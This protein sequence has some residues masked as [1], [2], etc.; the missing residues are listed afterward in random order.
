MIDP[1][2]RRST[3][4]AHRREPR[5]C[6][7]DVNMPMVIAALVLALFSCN[8]AQSMQQPIDVSITTDGGFTGRGL[9]TVAIKDTRV[10]TDRCDGELTKPEQTRIARL[11]RD[12]KPD[13][14]AG[15]VSK[16]HP[17]Q[18]H[19]TVTLNGKSGSFYDEQDAPEDLR[20]LYE[21]VWQVRQRV[22]ASCR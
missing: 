19:V 6:N 22:V 20:A 21:S 16:A 5:A 14:W 12:A 4:R 13:A 17:D 3:R 10:T 8:T 1:P 15:I 7:N 2:C 11:V 9:G 18:V